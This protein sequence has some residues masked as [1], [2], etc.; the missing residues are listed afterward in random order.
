MEQLWSNNEPNICIESLVW[1]SEKL[2]KTASI[3]KYSEDHND[4][5]L[6]DEQGIIQKRKNNQRNVCFRRRNYSS[7]E[8]SKYSSLYKKS[9]F[10]CNNI[11]L[12]PKFYCKCYFSSQILN[13]ETDNYFWIMQS[14]YL[15]RVWSLD[16]SWEWKLQL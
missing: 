10:R 13:L 6:N 16:I 11:A 4:A 1:I 9:T 2:S 14:D 15:H 12:N 3:K 5:Y 7:I 8:I